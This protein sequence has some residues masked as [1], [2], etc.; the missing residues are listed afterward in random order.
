MRDDVLARAGSCA[1]TI[2]SV[3]EQQRAG[4]ERW[5][6]IGL[7]LVVATMGYNLVEAADCTLD[8]NGR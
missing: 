7:W 3:G 6:R 8:G 5:F 1:V 2:G 4:Y